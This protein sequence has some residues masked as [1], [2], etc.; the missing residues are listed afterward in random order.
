V[1]FRMI[2]SN[3]IQEYGYRNDGYVEYEIDVEEVV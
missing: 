1:P 2:L 3:D